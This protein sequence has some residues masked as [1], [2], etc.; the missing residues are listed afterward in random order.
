[1]EHDIIDL[2]PCH[3]SGAAIVHP[4]NEPLEGYAKAV[5]LL[6]TFEYDCF[7]QLLPRVLSHR[8]LRLNC[9]LSLNCRRWL[10]H[11][12]SWGG[13]TLSGGGLTPGPAIGAEP[14]RRLDLR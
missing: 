10:Q 8:W 7:R 5:A 13:W 1:M 14:L 2:Q 3:S 9:G 4:V 12:S 6:R 11:L